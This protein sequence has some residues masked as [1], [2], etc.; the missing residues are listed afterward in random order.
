MGRVKVLKKTLSECGERTMDIN[1]VVSE[2]VCHTML[3]QYQR[4]KQR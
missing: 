4:S 1:T 2:R 3:F